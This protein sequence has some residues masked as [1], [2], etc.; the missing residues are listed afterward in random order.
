[1]HASSSISLANLYTKLCPF[2][3]ISLNINNFNNIKNIL[4]DKLK[5]QYSPYIKIKNDT[6]DF[7]PYNLVFLGFIF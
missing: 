1:M 2:L 4:I 6:K 3:T 5:S 7:S